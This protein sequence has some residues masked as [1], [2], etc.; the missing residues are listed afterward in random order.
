LRP[1]YI[2]ASQAAGRFL[3][4]DGFEWGESTMPSDALAK[5]DKAIWVGACW[6]G[7]RNALMG[8]RPFEGKK[9]VFW[10]DGGVRG[11]T[12][13]TPLVVSGSPPLS[14]LEAI[15]EAGGGILR[16]QPSPIA[17][18][19]PTDSIDIV[20]PYLSRGM[21][22]ILL[23]KLALLWPSCTILSPRYILDVI[24]AERC[25]VDG[26]LV[27]PDENITARAAP[28]VTGE[29]KRSKGTP[30]RVVSGDGSEGTPSRKRLRAND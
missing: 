11:D 17:D 13:A 24:S 14:T 2:A 22:Q 26:F 29:N 15:V 7:R 3:P 20:V 30:I 5:I 25:D 1:E 28:A 16:H 18:S 6:R 19:S 9:I 12:S 21:D 8:M 27:S 10:L 23:H 4:E